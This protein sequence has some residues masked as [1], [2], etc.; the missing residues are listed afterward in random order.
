MIF[1]HDFMLRNLETLKFLLSPPPT[2]FSIL[3]F[4][5]EF[6]FRATAK[7]R[8]LAVVVHCIK[9]LSKGESDF[10]PLKRLRKWVK[11]MRLMRMYCMNQ[12]FEYGV[13]IICIDSAALHC[14]K[15]KRKKCK[16][17]SR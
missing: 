2:T 10:N 8:I 1:L 17:F 3:L 14:F 15:K 4:S 6:L 13:C 16:F 12:I 9:I 7:I 11:N 5:P